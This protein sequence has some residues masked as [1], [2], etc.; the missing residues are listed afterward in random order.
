M[1]FRSGTMMVFFAVLVG[2]CPAAYPPDMAL[3]DD[4]GFDPEPTMAAEV[5]RLLTGRFDSSAQAARDDRYF[6]VQLNACDVE[7]A[8]VGGN[9]VYVEQAMLTSL[10]APYRQRIYLVEERSEEVVSVVFELDAPE[11]VV[12]ICD[13][14]AADRAQAI[15]RR[16]LSPLSGC[17]VALT[18]SD[19]GYVG[20]TR[21]QDCVNSFSGAVYATSDVTL[22]ETQV[23]TW[24]RGYDA[25]GRQ[26]WG[27]T[28]GAY[29][30]DR[31]E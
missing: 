2:G 6:E 16:T 11:Q 21:E 20:G 23:I 31:V 15:A 1:L 14:N 13:F 4:A 12:G 8:D 9:V 10:D 29:V 3:D 25:Q 5:A 18:P 7:A 27:A 28:A 19:G 24:D 30:F 26:V 17:E 22:T